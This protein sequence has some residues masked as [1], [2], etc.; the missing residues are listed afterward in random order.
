MKKRF[1]HYFGSA[2]ILVLFVA[3]TPIVADK[4]SNNGA[5]S[6]DPLS[7]EEVLVNVVT[8][9][10]NN[11]HYQPQDINDTFSLK[12][13][14]TYLDRLDYSKKFLIREDLDAL[15][16]FN[17]LIDDEVLGAKTAFFELS[18]KIIVKRIEEAKSYY[19]DILSEPF[20]F[21][22]HED[23]Q[24]DYEK[25]DYAKDQTELK[26]R[27]RKYLKY[28]TLVKLNNKIRSQEEELAKSD[29]V[30]VKSEAELEKTCREK[31]LKDHEQ[32]FKRMQRL[33]RQERYS[34]FINTIAA[35]FD[36]H[37]NYYPPKDKENFDISLS[38]RLEGIGATLQESDG[39]IKVTRIVP[40]S[41]SSRQGELKAGDF[42]LAVGQGDEEPVDIVDMRLDEAV[43]LIR[44]KKGTEVRLT[45]KKID[46][47][48]KVISIIRDVVILEETYAKSA[49][50]KNKEQGLRI[51]Y[52]YLPKFYA[53]FNNRGG[54]SCYKDV[55]KEIAKLRDENIEG[56]IL[57]LR[58]NGGGSLSDV[59][60]MGGLFIESGPIVQTKNRR[61][62][63]A[64]YRD[65]DPSVQ[66]TGPLVI[67]VNSLSASASEIL[68]A[69]M[70][71]YERAIIIGSTSTYGKGTVQRFENLDQHLSADYQY[72]KPLGS[73]KITTSKFY[74][75][76]GGATQWKGVI[77]DIKLPDT[78]AYIEV[79][80]KE[81]EHSMPWD[82]I[83]PAD[84]QKWSDNKKF[85]K[86][87]A[88]S[89]KR[90]AKDSS[91]VLIDE[92]AKR[93]KE[94][95]DHNIYSLNLETY[96]N[97]RERE[98]KEGAKYDNI[99]EN[100]IVSLEVYTLKADQ[101]AFAGDT[102]KITRNDEFQGKLKKDIYLLEAMSII[103]DIK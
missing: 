79:G 90:I 43:K 41:A 89:E 38:G 2:T 51:G 31:V 103:N 30:T 39:Y 48:T 4:G 44:G 75:V 74:R 18:Y 57:D 56:L 99:M 59:V 29:T 19:E 92:K 85:K 6:E 23:I 32:W 1:Y 81:L 84:Y 82:E 62:A 20:D 55:K 25:L 64:V 3:L 102:T 28:Q 86:A 49:V 80:E 14:E 95:R 58:N 11:G 101:E 5:Y 66:Y 47:S 27:W 53:D 13:Y 94:L 34:L 9:I 45:V 88:K 17:K 83:E 26:E 8:S 71:D 35:V 46:G 93:F 76:N 12:V 42:I 69:A 61:S 68:A 54:R 91:F 52:I 96:R 21:S 24:L 73:V 33:E 63:P 10:L 37:T 70:Q 36:P 15:V 72:L 60:D 50:V 16:K 22:K 87:I 40:G 67:M 77:P 100:E 7:K 97:E 98:K 78:Y 65:R